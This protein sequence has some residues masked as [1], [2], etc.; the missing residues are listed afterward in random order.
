MG[1]SQESTEDSVLD[2]YK[3]IVKALCREYGAFRLRKPV[4][5]EDYSFRGDLENFLLTETDVEKFLDAVELSFRMIDKASRHYEYLNRRDASA[6]ADDAISEL[7]KRFNEHGAGYHY[8]SG[9]IIRID[10]ELVHTEVMKPAL[11]LLN[12]KQFSGVQEE[13]LKSHDYYRKGDEKEALN[14]CLKAFESMMKAI[15]DKRKWKYDQ[16]AQ[17]KDLIQVCF[18]KKLIPGFWQ[19]EFS[20]LRSLLES[21]VPTGRNKLGGHGQGAKP[22]RVP[23]YLVSYMLHMT[24]SAIVF[25]GEAEKALP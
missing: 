17:A 20:A 6:I 21:S 13:F 22:I 10:S 8:A 3:R 9:E 1:G 11:R 15:C 7:N 4:L 2:A 18:E 12:D 23:P 19:S 16:N 25:L 24:A 14:W 5:N